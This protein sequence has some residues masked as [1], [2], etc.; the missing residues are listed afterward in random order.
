M[1]PAPHN[2][3]PINE[4]WLIEQS[5]TR[6]SNDIAKELGLNGRTIRRRLT[7]L[8][9]DMSENARIF[10]TGVYRSANTP[11]SA[12]MRSAIGRLGGLSLRGKVYPA[13]H[14]S[15]RRGPDHP[16]WKG[17]IRK[18]RNGYPDTDYKN[19]RKAVFERDNYTC[20]FCGIRGGTIHADH[21]KR[22]KDYP[23]L[24]YEVSN[25]RT[26]C[27]QCHRKTPTYGNRRANVWVA[28]AA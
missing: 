3:F 24:R 9:V 8:G 28:T 15:R 1:R 19:W 4:Q 25:G 27:V 21:I 11:M 5:K 6:S 22:W 10:N 7:F 23:N 12:E 17:G 18:E 26:L 14:F 16:R 13:D 20:Q 2:K